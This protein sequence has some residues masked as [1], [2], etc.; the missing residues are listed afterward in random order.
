MRVAPTLLKALTTCAAGRSFC[1]VSPW[2]SLGPVVYRRTPFTGGESARGLVVSTKVLPAKFSGPASS[3]T[4]STTRP[5]TAS[6]TRSPN[7]VASAK[8]P[9]DAPG[10]VHGQATPDVAGRSRG[11]A[12]LGGGW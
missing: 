12:C 1:I 5:K 3:M 2:D 8:V 10:V 4:F 9:A 6:T 7:R 11:A